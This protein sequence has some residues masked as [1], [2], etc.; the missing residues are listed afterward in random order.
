MCVE[1]KSDTVGGSP[2]VEYFCG[3][4]GLVFRLAYHESKAIHEPNLIFGFS[5]VQMLSFK[6]TIHDQSAGILPATQQ[7]M[8]Q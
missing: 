7:S 1:F 4:I 6:I 2:L 8:R 5:I 3:K